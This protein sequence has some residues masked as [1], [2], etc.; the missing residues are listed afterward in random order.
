M[1][2]KN[3]KLITNQ[4]DTLITKKLFNLKPSCIKDWYS[5]NVGYKSDNLI[6][7]PLGLSNN[8]SP[9][10]I[11]VEDINFSGLTSN[12]KDFLYL[13][14]SKNTNFKERTGIYEKFQEEEW[15]IV[16]NQI[17]LWTNIMILSKIIDLYYVHGEMASIH[18]EY[19][20]LYTPEIF[21]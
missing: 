2:L 14:F 18:T 10:N 15:S 13:N 16:E 21:Q 11:L 6:P 1:N 4:T 20:K 8:Y 9:K 19:G 17:Y 12:S 5:I 7:I 3:L